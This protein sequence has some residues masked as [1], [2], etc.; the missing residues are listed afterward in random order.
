MSYAIYT[1]KLLMMIMMIS[2]FIEHIINSP[3]MRC[4]SAKQVVLQMSSECQ[5]GESCSLQSGW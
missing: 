3:Q 4:R 1:G 2:G 5:R